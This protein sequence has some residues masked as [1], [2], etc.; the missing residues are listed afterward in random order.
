MQYDIDYF[1]YEYGVLRGLFDIFREVT[2]SVSSDALEAYRTTRDDLGQL[3][4]KIITQWES[5]RSITINLPHDLHVNILSSTLEK[6][7][8]EKVSIE[9]GT[10]LVADVIK[11][12]WLSIICK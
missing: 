2:F 9:E 3:E 11:K 12:E 10:L 8:E 4:K 6:L 1:T 5:G 7:Y